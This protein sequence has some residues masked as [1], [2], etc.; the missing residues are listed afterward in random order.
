M[1]KAPITKTEFARRRGVSRGRVSDWLAEG[2]ISGHAIVGKGRFA[3][4]DEDEACRQL[5]ERI[6]SGQRFGNGLLTRLDPGDAPAAGSATASLERQIMEQRLE[7]LE[8]ENREA[9]LRAAV[10]SGTLCRA[11]DA[12]RTTTAEIT[13]VIIEF[14]G[15]LPALSTALA[16]RFKLPPRDCLHLMRAVWRNARR[17]AAVATRE[18]SEHL[19]EAVG[20]DLTSDDGEDGQ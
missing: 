19:P 9:S 6:D 10:D 4:I 12:R 20:F 13:R 17:S 8:R 18:R 11:A 14:E 7:R 5:S 16:A 15:T 1:S 3:K 2:K